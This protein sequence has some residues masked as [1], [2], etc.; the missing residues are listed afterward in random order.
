MFVSAGMIGRLFQI[1]QIKCV[2]SQIRLAE[3]KTAINKPS[4]ENGYEVQLSESP[5]L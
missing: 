5:F 2:Y 4:P 1:S 3:K